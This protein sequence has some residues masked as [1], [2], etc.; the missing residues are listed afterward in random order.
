MTKIP[1][2]FI[3]QQLRQGLKMLGSNIAFKHTGV[4]P[5]ATKILKTLKT[6]YGRIT[7]HTFSFKP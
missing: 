7:V 2:S 3:E 1:N 5:P 4:H 6:L